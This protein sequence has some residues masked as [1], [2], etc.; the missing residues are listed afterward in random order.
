MDVIQHEH[1]GRR[2]GE[3]HQD[4]ADRPMAAIALVLERHP[5]AVGERCQRREDLRE[6]HLDLVTQ[7]REPFRLQARDVLVQRI[8]ENRERGGRARAPMPLPRAR[9]APGP[10]HGRQAP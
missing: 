6:L 1:E 2:R 5:A 4:L 10:R 7:R 3:P 9:G 8:E